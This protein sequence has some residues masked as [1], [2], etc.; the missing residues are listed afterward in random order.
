M[1]NLKVTIVVE[2]QLLR[3]VDDLV[4]AGVFANRSQLIQTAIEEK[5]SRLAKNRLARECAKL[6]KSEEQA[7]A[8][9][10]W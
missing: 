7:F 2:S 9:F 5:V 6:D 4:N 10:A 1:G 8:E 3:K